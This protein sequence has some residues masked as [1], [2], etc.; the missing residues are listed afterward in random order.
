MVKGKPYKIYRT[1]AT[2]FYCKINKL[3]ENKL[4]KHYMC[5]EKIK[6]ICKINRSHIINSA[7]YAADQIQNSL[8]VLFHQRWWLRPTFHTMSRKNS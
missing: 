7:M 6:R 3:E 8:A 5:K 4:Q 2:D 1:P